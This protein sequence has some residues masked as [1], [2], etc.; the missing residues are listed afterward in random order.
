MA[1]MVTRAAAAA[2][3][4]AMRHPEADKYFKEGVRS[5]FRQWTALELA[6]ANQWGGPTSSSKAEKLIDEV[7]TLFD[8]PDRVYKDVSV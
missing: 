3:E 1:A 2:A 7:L 5:V 6:V 8:G 4:R